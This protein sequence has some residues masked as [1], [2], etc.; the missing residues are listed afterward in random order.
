MPG[1]FYGRGVIRKLWLFDKPRF[2]EHLK[3]L[4]TDSRRKRFQGLVSDAYVERYGERAFKL[5]AVLYGYFDR[6]E[7]KAVA[8]LHPLG[9]LLT[10]DAEV[11]FSVEADYQEQG[12]GSELFK[13]LTTAARNRG[14]KRLIMHCLPANIGMRRLANR[15]G[16]AIVI[17]D[18]EA[19]GELQAPMATPLSLWRE[20]MADGTGFA[21][22]LLEVEL[23]ALAA[24]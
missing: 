1:P 7:L 11:A 10:P 9:G 17:E 24:A 15:F 3:R 13:R 14:L 4:D 20:A 2:I 16:S 8:E 12:I 21:R 5:D 22:A 23:P 6:G 18:G 19:V